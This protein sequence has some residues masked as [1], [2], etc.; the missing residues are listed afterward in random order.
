REHIFRFHRPASHAQTF[1]ACRARTPHSTAGQFH[2]E[3]RGT[4]D[5][6]GSLSFISGAVG[7]RPF[8]PVRSLNAAAFDAVTVVVSRNI[9]DLSKK[10]KPDFIKHYNALM[11]DD[12]FIRLITRATAD[13]QSVKDRFT[14]AEQHLLA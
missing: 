8:R 9:G 3:R 7:D 2:L 1:A 11:A 13:E 6:I 5:F 4:K 14:I 10:G 12:R